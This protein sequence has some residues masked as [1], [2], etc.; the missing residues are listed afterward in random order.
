MGRL[1]LVLVPDN[2]KCHCARKSIRVRVRTPMRAGEGDIHK[3][4]AHCITPSGLHSLDVK[5]YLAK[6]C[7]RRLHSLERILFEHDLFVAPSK[8]EIQPLSCCGHHL[9]VVRW[10]DINNI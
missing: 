5:S 8:N 7:A 2:G 10:R 4:L 9:Y 3:G 6:Q 1:R